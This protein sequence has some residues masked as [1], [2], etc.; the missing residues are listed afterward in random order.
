MQTYVGSLKWAMNILHQ[1]WVLNSW[2]GIGKENY[3]KDVGGNYD[4]VSGD[5]HKTSLK[6]LNILQESTYLFLI[7]SN[8]HCDL[9]LLTA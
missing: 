6:L 3:F 2:S 5:T 9:F 8:L 7:K 1:Q 4:C